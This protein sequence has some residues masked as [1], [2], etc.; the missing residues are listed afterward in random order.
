MSNFKKTLKNLL[1]EKNEK[2]DETNKKISEL[3]TK[4]NK[5]FLDLLEEEKKDEKELVGII[6]GESSEG[7][8]KLKKFR[9]IK[10]KTQDMLVAIRDMLH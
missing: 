6:R 2:M 7:Y 3:Y 5:K 4:Y 10:S 9:K 1:E 8:A